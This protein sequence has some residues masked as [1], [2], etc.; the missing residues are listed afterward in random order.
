MTCNVAKPQNKWLNVLH[1]SVTVA[2]H[3]EAHHVKSLL[4]RYLPK[5]RESVGADLQLLWRAIWVA[6]QSLQQF[7]LDT[8]INQCRLQNA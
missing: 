4:Q 5:A 6:F 2:I 8:V 3:C 7:V 1:A